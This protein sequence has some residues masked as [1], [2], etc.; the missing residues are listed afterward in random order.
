MVTEEWVDEDGLNHQHSEITGGT[1]RFEDCTGE[2]TIIVSV[3]WVN[4]S[5]IAEGFGTISY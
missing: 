1:G 2:L 5:F 4:M 3:D